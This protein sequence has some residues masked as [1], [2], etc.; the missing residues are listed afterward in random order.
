MSVAVRRIYEPPSDSD[1]VR[2]LIDRLWPRGVSRQAARLDAWCQA[3]APSPEARRWY[4]RRPERWSEFVVRY[5]RELAH[6]D[7]A[8]TLADLRSLAATRAVTLL[9]AVEDV[10]HSAAAVLAQV[11]VEES[12]PDC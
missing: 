11:L 12:S 6:P 2:L 3:L 4:G 5:R 1:E 10:D 8:D 7:K 9:T